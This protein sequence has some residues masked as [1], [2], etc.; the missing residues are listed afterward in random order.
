MH[1]FVFPARR[2]QTRQANLSFLLSKGMN[3]GRGMYPK[4]IFRAMLFP[5]S[6]KVFVII[7]LPNHLLARQRPGPLLPVAYSVGSHPPFGVIWFIL[8]VSLESEEI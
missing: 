4:S 8:L 1:A 5:G 3:W 7:Y 6:A 2:W